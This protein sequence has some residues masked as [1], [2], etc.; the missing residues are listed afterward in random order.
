MRENSLTSNNINHHQQ[1]QQQPCGSVSGYHRK[2]ER[3]RK[4]GRE[5]G[6]DY[7]TGEGEERKEY[8]LLSLSLS[9]L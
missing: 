5:E 3:G 4:E 9:A 7:R 1:Q 2:G 8:R 6:R